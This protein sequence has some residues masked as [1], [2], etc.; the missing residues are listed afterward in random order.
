MA[1]RDEHIEAAL[2]A[3]THAGARVLGVESYGLE[4]GCAADL[5]L[6]DAETNAEAVVSHPPDRVVVKRGVV[7]AG[8]Q[9]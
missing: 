1:R 8:D 3:V 7:V 9:R 4:P 2:E 6:V 5:V